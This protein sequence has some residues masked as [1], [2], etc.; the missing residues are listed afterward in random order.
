MKTSRTVL[1]ALALAFCLTA[2]AQRNQIIKTGWNIGPLPAIAY[3]ADKGFQF[4][5]ILQLYNY[6]DGSTY[7]NY[8]SKW[9]LESSFFTKGSQLYTIMYDNMD[10]FNGIRMS[11]AAT[12]SIDKAMDFYGFNGYESFYD[13]G[14]IA[15]G[16]SGESFLFSPFYK[17]ARTQILSKIDFTGELAENLKWELGYHASYFKI[18]SIN[19]ES[20]NK[21][22][23]ESQCFPEDQ[24]TLYDLYKKWGLIGEDEAEGGFVS[25]LRFGLQYDTRDKEGAPTRGIWADAHMIVAPKFLGTKN[26]YNRYSLTWRQ[27]FPLIDNNILT[28]AYRLNYQG[29]IGKNAP[30]YILPYQTFIG[31]SSDKDG[32]GGYRTVRGILRDRVSGLDTFC[33]NAEL[34]W[35]FVQFQLWRQNISFG[36]SVF[37]DGTMVTRGRKMNYA[38]PTG[39]DYLQEMMEHL[40]YRK[41]GADETIHATVGAGLRFIMNENFIVAFEYGTPFSHLNKNSSRYNQDGNGAFYINLGYLF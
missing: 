14:R 27:Y 22:K 11:A 20:I 40:S 21:G 6:G 36:L 30:F 37:S 41:Q 23:D 35:R 33:Y 39:G 12:A 29:I 13:Y 26:P 31:E 10:L 38:G 8:K 1:T 9:Y 5:A 15:A 24:P 17:I 16:S 25:A 18:G 19:R 3:D 34:R 2:G 28:L 32:F 7:P 4:G